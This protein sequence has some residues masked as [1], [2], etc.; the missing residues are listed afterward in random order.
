MT[1]WTI[2]GIAFIIFMVVVITMSITGK[3]EEEQ[4]WQD[5][6]DYCEENDVDVVIIETRG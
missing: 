3:D 1:T 2:A 6:D 4:F 5:V